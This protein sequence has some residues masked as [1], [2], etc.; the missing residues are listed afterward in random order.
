VNKITIAL[1]G[2]PNS[3]KTT[4]FNNLTGSHQHVGNYPGVTVESKEGTITFRGYHIR[5]IDLPGTYSLSAYS[6]DEIVARNVILDENPDM[7]VNVVDSSNL[8]RNLYFVTQLME[9]QKPI[10]LAMNM[11]DIV[12]QQGKVIDYSLLSKKIGVR[13][14]PT[15]GSKNKGT[16][17][18]LEMVIKLKEDQH[19]YTPVAVDYG[20]EIQDEILRISEIIK[21]DAILSEKLPVRWVAIKLLENDQRTIENI[22]NSPLADKLLDQ[23]EKSRNHLKNH[24]GED[25]EV[26]IADRRYGFVSGLCN[27]VLVQQGEDK[28]SLTDKIDRIVLNRFWGLPIF[29]LAMYTI[30]KFTFTLSEPVVGWFETLFGWLEGITAALL[31]EGL[32]QSFLV[33]GL[34]GGV[35][36][37]LGFFP[38]IMF[39]FFAIAFYEDTGYMARAVFIMDRIMTRFGLHGKSFLP[40]MLATNGCAVPAIMASRTID[41]KRDRLITMLVTPFMICGAKLPIFA[42]FIGAFFAAHNAANLMFLLYLLSVVIAFTASLFL[43]KVVFKGQ[44]SYLVMELPPYRIPTI[45][46]LLLKMW[47]RGWLYLKKAGTIILLISVVMW[48]GFTFPQLDPDTATIT[49]LSEQEIAARQ[50]ENSYAGRIG[51]FL[52]PMVRPIGQDWRGGIALLAGIAAKEVVVSTFGTI[53]SMGEVDVEEPVSLRGAMQNDPNWNPLK[54]FS[55]MLF[56]LIYVPCFV[57]VAV[58]YRES[59]SS[60]KWTSVLLFG[61]TLL[62]W[63]LSF[64][65]YQI[66]GLWI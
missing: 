56:S 36:G 17:K 40:L 52:E 25:P 22:K 24:F 9:L 13:I 23:K 7:I 4:V 20:N 61:S 45:K 65:V 46:G 58:F 11:T 47:E 54:A 2:N 48:V 16:E 32:L 60:L 12:E 53:Y 35:G 34:I 33:D 30:F 3:G 64:L 37:V 8:E 43:K 51:H 10:I 14:V 41:N 5:I 44:P 62:A 1:T 49:S 29:A 66:G 15:I 63:I 42:L 57:T 26:I 31:P 19:E 28:Y 55:F 50:I 27:Q 21:K 18:L 6:E 39:M 59:G 38:L